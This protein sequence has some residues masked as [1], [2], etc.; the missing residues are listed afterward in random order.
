ML[1]VKRNFVPLKNF[2]K[3][4]PG[5]KKIGRTAATK[6]LKTKYEIPKAGV[7]GFFLINDPEFNSPVGLFIFLRVVGPDGLVGTI[8]FLHHAPGIYPM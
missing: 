6:P 5:K 1:Q 7:L 3:K 8:S 4:Y 2:S